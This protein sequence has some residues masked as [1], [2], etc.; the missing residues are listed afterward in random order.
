MAQEYKV[1]RIE[2]VKKRIE[3]AKAIVLI[4]YKG[5]NA[6][7]TQELRKYMHDLDVDYFVEKNTLI[8]NALNAFGID[9]IDEFLVGPT[10]IAVSQKDEIAPAK[11]IVD[12]IKNVTKD[13]EFPT[14]KVGLVNG[15]KMDVEEVNTLAKLPSKDELIAKTIYC[16]KS[17]ITGFVGA[18]GGII[19]KFVYVIDAIEKQQS[20]N[21]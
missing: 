7:E 1:K 20:E 11:A 18:L 15:T 12:F 9:A 21:N 19:R 5:L 8:K 13:K 4:D 17:P 2:T 10:A 3:D 6:E 14:I 16:F